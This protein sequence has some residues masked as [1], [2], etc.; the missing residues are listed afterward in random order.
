V[1]SL[2]LATLAAAALLANASCARSRCCP[3]PPTAT[4]P[5]AAVVTTAVPATAAASAASPIPFHTSGFLADYARLKPGAHPGTWYWMKDGIDLRAYDNV[6][7]EPIELRFVP[8]SVGAAATDEQRAKATNGFTKILK[9]RLSPYF[10]VLDAAAPD[11]LAVRIAL[12]DVQPS[13]SGVDGQSAQVGGATLEGEI[14]DAV[15]S[16]ILVTFVSRIEGSTRGETAKEEW[17]PVEG[18]FREWA[19]RLLDFLELHAR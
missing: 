1:S 16:E 4:A 11:T 14:K 2:R 8:G 5:T 13:G 15:T 10:P 3:C 17:R 12:T 7:F 9:D 18:A 19:D 6:R